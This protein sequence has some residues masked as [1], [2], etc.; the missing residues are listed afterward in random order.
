ME[1]SL[2]DIITELVVNGGSAKS[3]AM[4]AMKAARLG[5]FEMAELR[6]KEASEFL[7]KAHHFQTEMIQA[8]AREENPCAVSLIMVHGQDHLI[9]AMT[10]RDIAIEMIEVYKLIHNK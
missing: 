9:S 8:E 3:K 10:T 7:Q 4:Q 2:E 6:I 1:I 5:D